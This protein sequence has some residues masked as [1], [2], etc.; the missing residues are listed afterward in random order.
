MEDQIVGDKPEAILGIPIA[1][2]DPVHAQ[3]V[4]IA[5]LVLIDPEFV[6]IIAVQPVLGAEP[7][8]AQAILYDAVDG[9]LRQAIL[10]GEL[11]ELDLLCSG[12]AQNWRRFGFPGSG[13]S[14][15]GG[16]CRGGIRAPGFRGGTTAKHQQQRSQHQPGRGSLGRLL[17][18]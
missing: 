9:A 17:H 5:G 11:P 4:R 16:C 15:R 18:S 12:S 14:R 8:K 1:A 3:A 6:A 13:I 2:L 10:K 7:H